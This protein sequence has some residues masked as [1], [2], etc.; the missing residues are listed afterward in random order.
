MCISIFTNLFQTEESPTGEEDEQ[1][2]Y[3]LSPILDQLTTSK[4]PKENQVGTVLSV[5]TGEASKFPAQLGFQNFT[6]DEFITKLKSKLLFDRNIAQR[7]IT[8]WNS[9]TF[10]RFHRANS[11][12]L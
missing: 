11:T 7:K 10:S 5:L 8:D 4:I 6:F 12:T 1:Y 9:I 3:C 2:I